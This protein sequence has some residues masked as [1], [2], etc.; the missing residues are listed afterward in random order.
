[1]ADRL[2][3]TR[4][5][6]LVGVVLLVGAGLTVAPAS[7]A[8]ETG[9]DTPTPSNDGDTNDPYDCS[10]FDS[11]EQVNAVFNPND[12]ASNLDDD[13]NGVAC[14]G[15]FPP[16]DSGGGTPTSTATT[17]ATATATETA[18]DEQTAAATS[19]ETATTVT[20]TAT[21]TS[22]ETEAANK[23]G[24]RSAADIVQAAQQSY[25][26]IEDFNATLVSTSTTSNATGTIETTNTTGKLSVKRPSKLRVEYREPEERAG[27]IIVSN[28]TTTTIYDA[29]NNTV[30]TLNTSFGGMQAMNQTGY[31]DTIERT[32]I[33]SN[34]SYEGT[35][36]VAGE[37]TFV[38][39]VTPNT[40]GNVTTGNQT[41]YLSQESYLPV[42]TVS[43]SSF[44][45]GN[46]TTTTRST[47]LLRDLQVNIGLSD[48]LFE[49]DAPEDAE[50]LGGFTSGISTY[51]S[52]EEVQQN[53]N[54]TVC[55]PSEVPDGYSF[56]NAT[57]TTINNNT[58]VS[59]QY[60]NG[61]GDPINDSLSVSISTA[62]S[63]QQANASEFGQNVSID[64]QS[65]TYVEA[66]DSG[67]VTFTTD[68][69]RYTISGPFSQDELIS[70]AES[71]DCATDGAPSDGEDGAT[72]DSEDSDLGQNDED[73]DGDGHVDEDGEDGN[74]VPSNDD[75]DGDGAI[76][77]DD[78]PDDG[79]DGSDDFGGNA[80]DDD[81]GDGHAD[82]DDEEDG[83]NSD[84]EDNDGD[85]A[86]DE[87]DE[88]DSDD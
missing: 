17:T 37:K 77:E 70:I 85:G 59:L 50:R 20:Q 41:Y 51:D 81:D 36:T 65:G 67:I 56:Q 7:V 39:S 33:Q 32:L 63:E 38:L 23:S 13:G 42:K 8:Q 47:T 2:S 15:Q 88:P 87:D 64:G 26:D 78:E 66:G 43:E 12:D 4:V 75:D 18:T 53:T 60:T 69:L 6:A 35:A 79:D 27:D 3:T 61:S 80:E 16:A 58:S 84:D 55:E 11:R 76:D 72:G 52:I 5:L 9:V 44:T 34:V 46:E 62:R 71:I 19:T 82:E 49:F 73:D 45:F 86:V 48:S 29:G 22:S 54:I 24:E 28:G 40:T 68:D 30:R 83:G 10:D 14:E 31:I 25:S 1:M 21:T 74:D 57:V